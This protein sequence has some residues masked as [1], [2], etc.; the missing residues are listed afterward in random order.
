M[1]SACQS[2]GTCFPATGPTDKDRLTACRLHTAHLLTALELFLD[3]RRLRRWMKDDPES[4]QVRTVGQR[5]SVGQVGHRSP[6]GTVTYAEWLD[7][8]D[9]GVVANTIIC[10][11]HQTN[12][13]L[14][15]QILLLAQGFRLAPEAKRDKAIVEDRREDETSPVQ[16]PACPVCDLPMIQRTARRGLR[17]GERFWG[18]TGYPRCHGLRASEKKAADFRPRP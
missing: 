8:A 15:R 10:L 6:A 2:P 13:L 18:C 1:A 9:P 7:Q 4:R 16:V 17:A 5:H 11:L 14:D 3:Q 12:Y